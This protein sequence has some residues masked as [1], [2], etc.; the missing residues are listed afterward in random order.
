MADSKFIFEDDHYVGEQLFVQARLFD[1]ISA[2]QAQGES[3]VLK[4]VR[5]DKT[6]ITSSMVEDVEDPGLYTGDGIVDIQGTWRVE[7]TVGSPP[8]SVF[9]HDRLYVAA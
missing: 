6:V 9:R 4:F 3:P 7:I 1:E 5:P 2:Q 8:R